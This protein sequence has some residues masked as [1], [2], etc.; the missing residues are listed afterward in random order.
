[1]SATTFVRMPNAKQMAMMGIPDLPE[2]AFG[3]DIPPMQRKALVRAMGIRPQ[4]GGGGLKA[5]VAVV[6]AV[7]IPFV[8]PAIAASIGVSGAIAG[9]AASAG[10][11]AATAATVGSVVG[12]AIVGA[13]LGAVSAAVT[14]GD[15]GRGALMGG[16]GSGISGYFAAPNLTPNAGG[17]A[18]ATSPG[19]PNFVGPVQGAPTTTVGI[20]NLG[21]G[22][23]A[24]ATFDP[25]TKTYMLANG[26]AVDP[27]AIAYGGQ[28]N[29][30]LAATLSSTNN[31]QGAANAINAVPGNLSVNT[32]VALGGNAANLGTTSFYNANLTPATYGGAGSAY[33]GNNAG[34]TYAAQSAPAYA[35][36]GQVVSAATES[37]AAAQAAFSPT[38]AANVTTPAATTTGGTTQ[39][40]TTTGGPAQ[41]AAPATLS[42]ALKQKLTN[43]S[44]QAD[45]VLRAAGQLVG[46][47]IAGDGLSEEEKAL[48]AEQRKELE[49]LR[50][51]NK[52][53]FDQKV[54]QALEFAGESR[55]FDP[56]TFG[57][58]AARQVQAAGARAKSEGLRGIDSRR[59]G[60]RQAEARRYDLGTST[61]AQTAY[62]QGM[63]MAEQN[64][65][66]VKQ[67]G[68][69]AIP[70]QGYEA[71][72]MQYASYLGN[73]YDSADR[74]RRAAAGDVG[75]LFGGFT[76]GAK[77][78][79]T[80]IKIS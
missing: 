17:P 53:L 40:G 39:G 64:K 35:Q 21:D 23:A 16:L 44:S 27:S 11:T 65:L 32:P 7:A 26:T 80:T 43:P 22:G 50:T 60:L 5:V 1:M 78:S 57:L 70:S 29:S 69:S 77:S 49:S 3:G 25:A 8:A 46:S 61:G 6:A 51:T 12:S 75:D 67:A 48:V 66:R 18:V 63:D 41:V 30:S 73:M 74:R 31:V 76:G 59:A 71:S 9:A 55:Y 38:Y 20:A 37:A 33:T 19:S 10:I 72:N 45:F 34:G 2:A 13:G 79:G 36:S 15:V 28:V 14:G 68:L 24:V 56:E 58:R 4:G 54:Q 42:E 47:Q 52:A 62:L